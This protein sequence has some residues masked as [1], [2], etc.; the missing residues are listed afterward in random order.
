MVLVDGKI[1]VRDGEATLLDEERVRAR[2][3]ERAERA[4]KEAGV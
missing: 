1:A 4:R 3:S 2:A